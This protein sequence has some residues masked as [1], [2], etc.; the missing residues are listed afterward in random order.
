MKSALFGLIGSLV[1]TLTISSTAKAGSISGA[2]LL[3]AEL[4]EY[5]EKAEA[6]T[7]PDPLTLGKETLW[8]AGGRNTFLETVADNGGKY[9]VFDIYVPPNV[10]P[11]LHFHNR[12]DEWFYVV[13]G[14]PS[15]Q[16][17]DHTF[18]ANLGTLLFSPEFEL[19]AFLNKTK[20]PV[21]ML[22]FYAQPPESDST[23]AGNIE[24]FFRE[25]GQEVT[26]PFT[27]P[28]FNPAELLISGPK[29]GLF[30]PSTFVFTAPEF[31]SNQVSI[32]RT[33]APDEAASV[34]LSLENGLDISVE[35]GAGQFLRNISLPLG[36]GNQTLDLTLKD[37]S[38]GSYLGLL[39]NKSVLRTTSV[40]ESSSSI[41]LL[42]F[43]VLGLGF[44][45]KKKQQQF[46]H[47]GQ[48][49]FKN[50]KMHTSEI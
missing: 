19:H 27:P 22:L 38:E 36:L 18:Q 16:H 40:P 33:G 37:P 17:Q 7:L 24:E 45:L 49:Q 41:G 4:M 10:G 42:A 28:P 21:R 12:E 15:F 9:S 14:N 26:D 25:V 30:F 32:L 23:F 2:R 48:F 6:G 11:P 1:L 20:D 29:Y 5:I 8:V 47:I 13:E 34:I 35:F 39:Q 44:L 46:N 3:P 50:A 43:G 31:T